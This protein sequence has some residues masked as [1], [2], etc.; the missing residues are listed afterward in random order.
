[1]EKQN[2]TTEKLTDKAFLRLI[3]TSVLGI[4]IC[5]VC[6]CSS[7]FAWF[8]DSAP[9]EGNEIKISDELLLTVTLTQ[10]GVELTGL[11]TGVEL[12]AGLEYVVTMKLDAGS[13]SGYCLIEANGVEYYSDYI[14]RNDDQEQ[15]VSFVLKVDQAQTVVFT[16]R[17]GIYSG[18]SDV[19]D[20]ILLIP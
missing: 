13:S 6:L 1:M 8:V 2:K 12:E 19:V 15:T 7:T 11:D 10:N 14:A 4:F 5:I 17:W 18:E 3:V 20:G 9:S 16:N